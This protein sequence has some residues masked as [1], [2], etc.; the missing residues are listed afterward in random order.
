M[1]KDNV[2]QVQQDNCTHALTAGMAIWQSSS[3]TKSQHGAWTWNP[4]V[5]WRVIGTW[6]LLGRGTPLS[7]TLWPL[8]S[9]PHTTSGATPK[10]K[11]GNTNRT[12]RRKKCQS[13]GRGDGRVKR[14]WIYSKYILWN[15][16]VV[17]KNNVYKTTCFLVLALSYCVTLGKSI[18]H[19]VPQ[20]SLSREL[21]I[22]I[23]V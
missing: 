1:T 6:G 18:R 5:N 19:S 17:N 7:L 2:F 22:T 14:G 3:H 12:Q 16:Q 13:W 11:P 21:G 8:V 15:A 9:P 20:V 4:T 10:A 23:K